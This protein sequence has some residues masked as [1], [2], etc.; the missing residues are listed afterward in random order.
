MPS[1]KHEPPVPKLNKPRWTS[2]V[3]TNA[4]EGAYTRVPDDQYERDVEHGWV[5][6]DHPAQTPSQRAQMTAMLESITAPET[7]C[8]NRQ[9][10]TV[11]GSVSKGNP[12]DSHPLDGP[13]RR[14]ASDPGVDPTACSWSIAAASPH[15]AGLACALPV[16]CAASH[17]F[18]PGLTTVRIHVSVKICIG[19]WDAKPACVTSRCSPAPQGVTCY[20]SLLQARGHKTS[21]P[22]TTYE[23]MDTPPFLPATGAA[24][25]DERVM[26]TA[27]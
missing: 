21:L 2:F 20:S 5:V 19:H 22:L 7:A 18:K 10:T 14:A 26:K 15:T 9:S 17:P 16:R 13:H 12:L 6:G 11:P 3:H 23:V 4:P 24:L 25:A 27:L 1:T 8:E